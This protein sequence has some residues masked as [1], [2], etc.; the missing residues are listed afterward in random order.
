[1]SRIV[2]ASVSGLSSV[3]PACRCA[4]WKTSQSIAVKGELGEVLGSD[5]GRVRSGPVEQS[6]LRRR[7]AI[8]GVAVV[9]AVGERALFGDVRKRLLKIIKMGGNVVSSS[10]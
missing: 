7:D 1:M 5:V 3:T 4:R 10:W 9:D 6:R 8:G 2:A